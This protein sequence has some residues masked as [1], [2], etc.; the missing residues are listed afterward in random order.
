MMG[1]KN[2]ILFRLIIHNAQ[3][4]RETEYTI[5][6]KNPSIFSLSVKEKQQFIK[7]Q[8]QKIKE[9]ITQKYRPDFKN[10]DSLTD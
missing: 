7:I 4:D 2:R 8:Q 1:T 9:L 6:D 10:P 5:F 3:T